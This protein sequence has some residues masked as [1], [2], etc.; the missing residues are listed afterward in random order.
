MRQ[1]SVD[2][3][4]FEIFAEGIRNTVGFDWHPVT[5]ELWFTENGRDLLTHELPPDEINH[6]PTQGLHFFIAHYW[7]RNR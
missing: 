4:E 5:K 1:K 2:S 3:W 6:A 7:V